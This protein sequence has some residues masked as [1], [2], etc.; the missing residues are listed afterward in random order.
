LG[1]L[2]ATSTAP[3]V[4]TAREVPMGLTRFDGH[5]RLGV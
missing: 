4:G 3:A 1:M 5:P 2:V